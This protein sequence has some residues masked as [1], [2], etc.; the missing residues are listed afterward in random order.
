[1]LVQNGEVKGYPRPIPQIWENIS[2]FHVL[3]PETHR[4]Y[5]WYPLRVVK[6][7]LQEREVITGNLFVIEGDEVVQYE[8]K[9]EKTAEELEQEANQEWESIRSQRT[10]YLQECDWT[11]LP[12]SPLS[13]E[14]KIEWQIYRQALRDITTFPTPAEVIWP[15]SPDGVT[16]E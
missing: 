2:N 4:K 13:V 3:D 16:Y 6:V 11:Q 9:R 14:R 10:I 12:D 15:Q 1:M 8:Q 5:G 7:E